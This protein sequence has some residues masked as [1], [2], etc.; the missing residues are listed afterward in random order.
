MRGVIPNCRINDTLHQHI[1]FVSHAKHRT[2]VCRFTSAFA[3]MSASAMS[4]WPRPQ[5]QCRAVSLY[6]KIQRSQRKSQ[7]SFP[8]NHDTNL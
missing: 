6:C 8:L 1:T 4:V 5:A 2:F 7:A 3:L